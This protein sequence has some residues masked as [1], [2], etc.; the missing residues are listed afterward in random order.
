M[1]KFLIYV[2]RFPKW[3][4]FHWRGF[5]PPS[6]ARLFFSASMIIDDVAGRFHRCRFLRGRRLLQALLLA[7]D[8]RLQAFLDRVLHHGGAPILRLL[9]YQL[10]HQRQQLAVDFSLAVEFGHGI[11]Y[12]VAVAQGPENDAFAQRFQQ[13]RMLTAIEDKTGDAD[14]VICLHR[15]ADDAEGLHSYLVF[16]CQK[17]RFVVP[18]PIDRAA[19][20]ETVDLDGAGAFEPDFLDLLVFEKNIVV[21]AARIA[22]HL[23]P[24]GHRLVC[25]AVDIA[26]F[27]AVLRLAIED[28]ETDLVAFGRRRRQRDGGGD[29]RELE[30]TFPECLTW[31]VCP[32]SRTR[33]GMAING[34]LGLWFRQLTISL[35]GCG[36]CIFISWIG[37]QWGRALR[38]E[39]PEPLFPCHRHFPLQ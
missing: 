11:T 9:L 33:L 36:Q 12:L 6:A 39:R 19:R 22:L 29:E 10:R 24:L 18:D 30:I 16:G 5:S 13:H 1:L 3:P 34:G 4:V 31:H 15:L 28:V 27:D 21:L 32:V 8:H 14:D 23:V 26:A 7:A 35:I 2:C 38:A 20:H 25:D 37:C 17:M